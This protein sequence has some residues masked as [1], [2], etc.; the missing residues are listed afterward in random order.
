MHGLVNRSI[1]CFL[2]ETYGPAVWE[3][4]ADAAGLPSQ[5]FEAMLHYDDPVTEVLLDVAALRLRTPRDALLEDLGTFLVSR[6][7]LRRLLRFGGIDYADFLQSLAEL[8]ERVRLAIPDLDF[9]VLALAEDAPGHYRLDCG[10]GWPGFARVM[11]G[12]LR[13]MADDY[14][15]LVLIDRAGAA[16]ADVSIELLDMTYAT[17]RSF[18]LARP[19]AG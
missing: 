14:G 2:R 7:S 11:A 3:A 8:P 6:E 19:E 12:V 18:A 9:P 1:Q 17:G 13:A 10:G 15:A 5:G 4:I 16:D